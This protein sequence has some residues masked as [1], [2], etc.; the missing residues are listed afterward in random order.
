MLTEVIMQR[1]Y[2]K[3]R[4]AHYWATGSGAVSFNNDF[5]INNANF[6]SWVSNLNTSLRIPLQRTIHIITFFLEGLPAKAPLKTLILFAS[7]V[8]I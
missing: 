8:I 2:C 4:A 7:K 6:I 3:A 1:Q 5:N